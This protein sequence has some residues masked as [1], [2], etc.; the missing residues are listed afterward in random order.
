MALILASSSP[1]RQEL[2]Q[3]IN[4]QFTVMPSNVIENHSLELPPQELAVALARDKAMDIALQVSENDVVI[5]ADTIVTFAGQIFGKPVNEEDACRMLST[6]SGKEHHVITGLTV[7]VR[8]T[9]QIWSDYAI[10]KVK[11]FEISADEVKK[12]IATGEPFDKAGAY[13][14]QGKASLFVEKIDGCYFNVVGLPLST[15]SRLLK[16][17]GIDLL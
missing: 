13:A 3:Q 12:Y 14:I 4:C 2:L 15:L 5:G 17:A 11:F 6:L 1:R 9:K 8:R 16:K 7:I 10:T